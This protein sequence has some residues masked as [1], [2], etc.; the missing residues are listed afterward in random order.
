MHDKTVII[1]GGTSGIGL[2]AAKELA[3]QGA[4]MILVGRD[5]ER[6]EQALANL[7]PATD[8][9]H[10]FISADLSMLVEIKRVADNLTAT[11]SS[12]DVLANNAG[13]WFRRRQV[14]AEGFEQTFAINHLAYVAL[15]LALRDLLSKTPGARVI[16]TGSFVYRSARYDAENLQAE[17]RFSTN[18]TYAATKLYNLMF[19]RALSRRWWDNGITVNC[20]SPGFVATHFGEGEGGL[21]E[22]YYSFTRRLFAK[23]PEQ[24]ARTLV[25][26]AESAE[27]VRIT[28]TYFENCQVKPIASQASDEQLADDLL[29]RCTE[30]IGTG[31]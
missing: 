22:P 13:T 25:Y 31:S 10:R 12:I 23:T 26:L 8:R 18:S 20:F 6:G 14:T 30:M 11:E 5:R 19:T 4:R 7:T 28:G 2:A 1:T 17:K 21:L 27:V 3:R 16:N 29:R 15:T 9:P 24:G